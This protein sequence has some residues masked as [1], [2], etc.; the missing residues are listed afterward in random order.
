M[1]KNP[2]VNTRQSDREEPAE[3]W[4]DAKAYYKKPTQRV[5]SPDADGRVQT[6]QLPNLL[7]SSTQQAAISQVSEPPKP[8]II[9]VAPIQHPVRPRYPVSVPRRPTSI[10]ITP[11]L[12]QTAAK[13]DSLRRKTAQT[14]KQGAYKPGIFHFFK[15]FMRTLLGFIEKLLN[16]KKSAP[17]SP[18]GFRPPVVKVCC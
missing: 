3:I 14:F 6:G 16:S 10:G 4:P 13:A 2:H 1:S 9:R 7:R 8:N 15:V 11:T 18:V 12:G 17:K 5:S